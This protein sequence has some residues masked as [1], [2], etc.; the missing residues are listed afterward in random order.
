[1]VGWVLREQPQSHLDM[2][3]MSSLSGPLPALVLLN[4]AATRDTHLKLLE[5]ISFLI[6]HGTKL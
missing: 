1:V 5:Q 2:L 6:F 4:L 3:L